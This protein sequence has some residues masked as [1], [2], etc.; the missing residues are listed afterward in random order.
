MAPLIA[1]DSTDVRPARIARGLSRA[2]DIGP[3]RREITFEPVHE[4]P[5]PS[6]P[7]PGPPEQAPEPEPREPVPAGS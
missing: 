7:A 2:G 6:V 4:Q 3:I 5:A 1:P